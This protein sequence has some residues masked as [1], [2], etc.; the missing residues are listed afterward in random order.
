MP[1]LHAVSPLRRG[2]RPRRRRLHAA[3]L[4]QLDAGVERL[5]TLMISTV[6]KHTVRHPPWWTNMN[7][8][9]PH[10]LTASTDAAGRASS[11][12]LAT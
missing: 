12:A 8:C 3:L 1:K 11:A 2:H 10:L 5:D 4:P 9:S 7:P 6:I